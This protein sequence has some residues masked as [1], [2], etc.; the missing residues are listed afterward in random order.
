MKIQNIEENQPLGKLLGHTA[1]SFFK[2]INQRFKE[3]DPSMNAELGLLLY[4]IHFHE[5]IAQNT[6]AEH[7]MK[8]KPSITRAIDQL[9]KKGYVMRVSDPRDRRVKL[10]YISPEG[11]KIMP[12]F[13]NLGVRLEEDVTRG[14]PK[15]EIT[16]M[17][18][19]LDKIRE[20]LKK[21]NQKDMVDV[22]NSCE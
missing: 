22:H 7:F 15:E 2:A 19:A 17:K 13:I 5:G 18:K 3:H 21:I 9:E 20:N 14:I 10:L 8:D 1:K 6:L 11:K 4:K 16:V 12:D